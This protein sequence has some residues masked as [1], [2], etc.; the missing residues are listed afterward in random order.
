MQMASGKVV[1]GR[2]ELDGELPEGASVTVIARDND[3]T[4][5]AD[6]ETEK[7][8]LS[9]IAQEKKRKRTAINLRQPST[10][11]DQGAAGDVARASLPVCGGIRETADPA[12]ASR[13]TL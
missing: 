3:E 9:A 7:M 8:L 10:E 2:V 1:D 4:F 11:S 6:S 13:L 5:Q 12:T